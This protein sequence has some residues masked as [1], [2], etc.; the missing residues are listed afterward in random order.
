MGPRGGG[1]TRDGGV[2]GACCHGYGGVTVVSKVTVMAGSPLRTQAECS[3]GS[4]TVQAVGRFSGGPPHRVRPGRV[5]P[6]S[7]RFQPSSSE[8]GRP[9]GGLPGSH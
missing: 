9:G 6:S 2:G 1:Q 3:T 4:E 7:F 5:F 8:W